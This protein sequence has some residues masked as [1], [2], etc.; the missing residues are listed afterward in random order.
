[1][2]Y[3]VVYGVLAYSLF[4]GWF[5]ILEM[6]WGVKLNNITKNLFKIFHESD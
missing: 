2:W 6:K 1:M 5:D 4:F 3:I